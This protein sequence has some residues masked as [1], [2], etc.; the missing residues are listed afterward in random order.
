M[1]LYIRCHYKNS[2]WATNGRGTAII[3]LNS[4]RADHQSPVVI[5]YRPYRLEDK[6][7]KKSVPLTG[8]HQPLTQDVHH[9]LLAP[10]LLPQLSVS[11]LQIYVGCQQPNQATSAVSPSLSLQT[12]T[13]FHNVTNNLQEQVND[14]CLWQQSNKGN[15]VH[16]SQFTRALGKD[17]T[18]CKMAIQ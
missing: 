15:L 17:S 4:Y 12:C 6:K 10:A 7:K 9:F 11:L 14:L 8:R 18:L 2:A 16:L 3:T 5:A 1:N 13:F